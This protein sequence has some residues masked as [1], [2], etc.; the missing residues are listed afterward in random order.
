MNTHGKSAEMYMSCIFLIRGLHKTCT[1]IT[2]FHCGEITF[3]VYL[4]YIFEQDSECTYIRNI[5]ARFRNLFWR[6]KAISITHSECVSVALVIQ[7][8]QRMRRI[9]SSVSR[10]SL[11]C[12]CTLFHNRHDFRKI[13]MKHNV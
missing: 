8:A 11:L 10:P 6:G 3:C 1:V 4:H 7:H 2:L 5:E 9:L 12:F 13:I